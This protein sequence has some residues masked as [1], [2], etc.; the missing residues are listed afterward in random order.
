MRAPARHASHGE[1]GRAE[2]GRDAEGVVHHGREEIHVDGQRGPRPHGVVETLRDLEEALS[3]RR[4]CHA[5]GHAPQDTGASVVHLVHAVAEAG[6]ARLGIGPL[7]LG[8]SGPSAQATLDEGFRPGRVLDLE[9]HGQNVLVGPAV[10]R[11]L[12]GG[13]GRDDRGV[14]IGQGR[15][16]DAGGEGGGVELVVRVERQ[17]DV[18]DSRELGRR[19][20]PFQQVVE[21]GRV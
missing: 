13:D 17:D 1:D 21:V 18:E 19:L 4:L 15:H 12:E 5:L 8:Q 6:H 16:R 2:I 14:E 3:P 10:A 7:V 11:P 20:P 9:Q